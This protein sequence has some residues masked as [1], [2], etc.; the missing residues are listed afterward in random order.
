M[1]Q[2]FLKVQVIRKTEI[3]RVVKN[4]FAECKSASVKSS[5]SR[6]TFLCWIE[7]KKSTWY[8]YFNNF[9]YRKFKAKFT[10]KTAPQPVKP[11]RVMLHLQL[12]LVSMKSQAVSCKGK[13]YH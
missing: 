7:R 6:C 10:N 11:K 12:D 2:Y 9:K 8:N 1:L 5:S 4:T 3:K 13:A